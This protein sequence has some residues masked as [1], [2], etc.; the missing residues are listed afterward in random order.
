MGSSWF[1]EPE[2][3]RIPLS[4]GE[5]IAVKRRL[6]AGDNRLHVARMVKPA[7]VAVDALGAGSL[8]K[9]EIDSEMMGLSTVLAYL[10]D[11]SAPIS[12]RGLSIP[13]LTSALD[14]LDSERYAEI[15]AAVLAHEAAMTRERAEEKKR[16]AGANASSPTSPSPSVVTGPTSTS[17][18]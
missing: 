2:T 12:I 11:W 5:W 16:M 3:V 6:S 1:V 8:P 7:A 9:L 13:D 14:H 10:V 17:L 4:D 18:N 15:Q